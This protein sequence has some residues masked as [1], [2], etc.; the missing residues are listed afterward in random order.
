MAHTPVG[1]NLKSP[2]KKRG[3]YLNVIPLPIVVIIIDASMSPA[4]SQHWRCDSPAKSPALLERLCALP[5]LDMLPS[6]EASVS[7]LAASSCSSALALPLLVCRWK[8]LACLC[9]RH[10][11]KA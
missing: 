6:V 1:E 7:G 11:S 10:T 3:Q 9:A 5:L 4:I 8:S 2:L